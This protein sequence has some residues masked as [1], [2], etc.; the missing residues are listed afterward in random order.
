MTHLQCVQSVQQL[1]QKLCSVLLSLL[2]AAT[3]M[4]KKGKGRGEGEEGWERRGGEG[5][6]GWER[7]GGEGEG[8]ER[9]EIKGQRKGVGKAYT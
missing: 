8:R 3:E 9:D 1:E 2:I 5:E 7:R 6:E 4:G